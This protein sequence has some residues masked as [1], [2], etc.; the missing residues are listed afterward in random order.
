MPTNHLYHTWI[1]RLRQLRPGERVT[2]LRNAAWIVTG[3]F[4]SHSVHLS[5]I[6]DKIPGTA[7]TL[8]KARRLARFL[9]NPA[10]RVR[11][12]YEPVAR[13]VLNRVVE[14]GLEVR[15]ILDGTKIGFG[16]QL[17]LVAVAYRRRAIPIAWT[18]VKGKRGHSSSYKQVALLAY[19]ERLMPSYAEVLVVGDSEFGGVEVLRQLDKWQWRYVL[20]Q[21]AKHLVKGKG[22]AT[23][24]RFG[25]LVVQAGDSVWLASARLTQRHAYRV[26]LLAYWKPGE[27]EPWLLATNL[28]TSQATRR[29]YR[30][31]MWVEETFGDLK[32]HGFDLETTHLRHFLRLSRLTLLAALLYLWLISLGS[33]VI[34]CGQRRLVDRSDRSDL[35][36]FRIGFSM[37]ERYLTNEQP[38]SIRFRPYF[39]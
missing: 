9:N 25:D 22:Q 38:F 8:S 2:R 33:R 28:A 1:K 26:N 36:I 32:K 7:T 16:H 24:Q 4:Q 29:A 37:A 30:R 12:W 10:I 35:S 3:I 20:R 11:A 23:W 6:A 39:I 15:L 17:L 21:K 34:K 27:V 19:V 18:W 31:R 13:N 5:R 14:S